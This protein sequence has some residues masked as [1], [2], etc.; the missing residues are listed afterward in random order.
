MKIVKLQVLHGVFD[1]IDKI[2]DYLALHC[3][4]QA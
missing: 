1:S 2:S 4:I 3:N